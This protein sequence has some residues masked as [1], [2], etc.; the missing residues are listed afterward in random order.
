MDHNTLARA[1]HALLQDPRAR[2]ETDPS[3]L[4][5]AEYA[6]RLLDQG[7]HEGHGVYR[8]MAEGAQ[9]GAE[10]LSGDPLQVLSE[11][12]QNA[13]DAGARRLRVLWRPDTLLIA[14]DGGRLRLGD[15][16]LLGLPWLSGKSAD[17]G[18]TGR[19]GIG[20]STLR[21]LATTWEVHCHPFHVRFADLTLG[22]VPTPELP[23]E[24]SGPEW[25][26]FRIPLEPDSLAPERLLGW[27]EDWNDS[28]LL[29][30][31]H[32][33]H[34]EVKAGELRTLLALSWEELAQQR[35][36]V[37]GAEHEVRVQQA[38]TTDGA[39][40]RVYTVQ[41]PPRPDWVRSHK[42]LGATVPV[43]VALPLSRQTHGSV[44]AGLPIATLD[45]AARVH[46]HFDPVASREGFADSRLNSQLVPV[47]ADLWTAGVR[48]V[49]ERVDPTAWHLIPL[50]SSAGSA[51]PVRL[52][53]R[54]RSELLTRA[55]ESL[56]GE[57]TL[58]APDD[59]QAA[60]LAE[61]AV[62]EAALSEVLTD[63]DIARLGGV[64]YAFPS[65]AR[66]SGARWRRVLA[67]WRAAG[68]PDMPPE[69]RVADA[70]GLFSE[71]QQAPERLVRLAAVALETGHEYALTHR[72]CVVTADGRRLRP[73]ASENAFADGEATGPLDVLGIVMDLHSAYRE[74]NPWAKR[75]VG[76]LRS[77]D[78]LVS[79]DDTAAVLRIASRLGADGGRLPEADGPGETERLVALQRALAGTS[80]VLRESLGPGIGRAVLLDCFSYDAEGAEQHRRA[81]PRHAYLP[82]AL[83]SA[84]GDR[85]AVAARKTP[86]LMWIHRSYARSLLSAGQ[87]DGLSRTAFLRL[88]GVA[89]S[90]R[91]TPVD[92]GRYH[93]S[94]TKTYSGDSRLGLKRDAMWSI[95]GRREQMLNKGAD[96]T[97]DDLISDDLVAVVAHITND[98]DPQ[99]RRRRTAA[100][101]RTLAGPLTN[102]DQ[103]KVQ[104]AKAD[105]RWHL[106]DKTAAVWLWRLRA[107]A[108]LENSRGELCP[109]VQLT[110]RTGDT[111]ALYG[112][113]DPG[114]LHPEIQQALATRTDVLTALGVIGDP[115]VPRL[116]ERLRELREQ[117]EDGAD[118][119]EGLKAEAFLVYRAL[120]RRLT[121][122]SAD[123]S[124][125]SVEKEIRYEFLGEELVLTDQGWRD[126]DSCFRGPAILRGF[127]PFALT[128]P[129]LDPL[130]QALGIAEPGAGALI[131]VLKEIAG[132]GS[133][134]D[135]ECQRVTLHALRTLRDLIS[136][137][138]QL[139]HVG[140]RSRLRSLPLWTTAG[141]V[142]TKEQPVFVVADPR[143]ERSVGDRLPLWK[144]GGNVLQFVSLLKLLHVTL[145]EVAGAEVT[146]GAAFG[147]LPIDVTLTEDFRRGAVAL[148]DLLVR[149][150]PEIADGF[151]GWTWLAG[152]QVR[153]SPDLRIRLEPGGAHG[154]VELPAAAQIDR[155]RNTLFLR[156]PEALRTKA[157][158]AIA[159]HFVQDR[160][161]VAHA[162]RDVWE[163]DLVESGSETALTSVGQLD[164]EEQQRLVEQLDK[165]AQQVPP[166]V[167]QSATKPPSVRGG[168]RT[169]VGSLGVTPPPVTTPST[170]PGKPAGPHREPVARQLVRASS[171]EA[172]P[173]KTVRTGT[174]SRLGTA[175]LPAAGA[176]GKEPHGVQLPGPRAGGA[177]VRNQASRTGYADHDKEELVLRAL[178]RI[179]REQGIVLEDQR[180]VSGL[181]ADAVDSTGR[182]YEIKAHGR[183]VPGELS[184]TRAEFVRAWSER[185]NY[186][187]VIASRLEKG[188]GC[189]TLHLVNDPLHHF[190]V[191]PTT[192]V[193]LKGVRDPGV[194]STLY[195]WP[196]EG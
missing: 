21:A 167:Q 61:F 144:P 166:V 102:D 185:G 133:A 49:L 115:D 85:F 169:G 32:L 138:D 20:L 39:L 67:D 36:P 7:L 96:F 38:R 63:A 15:V 195:E 129:D 3:T 47:V 161:R 11:F 77:R 1:V 192:D 177:P 172:L 24:I 62:E 146:D 155:D 105:Q 93:S 181:G 42:A 86:G 27:F 135:A 12:V 75:V 58:L 154:T 108:W 130:W 151:T 179:L 33:E 139:V 150:E 76:W 148:Q 5:E 194:E 187:L 142:K 126:F 78:C 43:G 136:A 53:D 112:H 149:D 40:W 82:Q 23:E 175:S 94:H 122:R 120:A 111:E 60:S 147:D 88:L 17:A 182:F 51:K 163:E 83:E 119:A 116:M 171:F 97:L 162:W 113:E 145:L 69:V 89:D 28:S 80:P 117:C 66:D 140:M 87:A 54:I 45:V 128:G 22:P 125:A 68:A 170:V 9:R 14:H 124:R 64:P 26:V 44:H 91:L 65:A 10:T 13:D 114:Y 174:S 19:F 103:A 143:V 121:H 164:R 55:R 156:S 35:I 30:L 109:P 25:T 123:T 110:L 131:D 2:T 90:P 6:V 196:D 71:Q 95:R 84:D 176:Q 153:L 50:P 59:G 188:A 100:L 180:G 186:T 127:R 46:T 193:K 152:L 118:V 8:L 190:A 79:R 165:R 137:D 178:G 160:S 41:V 184:L 104:M 29:F 189:S 31:R 16:L 52:Q 183:S 173:R 74:D 157:G 141:W 4:E 81:E 101:L 191:E 56:A 37:D 134:P 73:R 159:A 34:L 132:T 72:A 92:R 57:L 168:T 107:T 48:D 98:K 99:E 70:L 158:A 106:R 18:S